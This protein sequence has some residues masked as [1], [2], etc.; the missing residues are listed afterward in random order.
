M[1]NQLS[2]VTV[3]VNQID[4][5]INGRPLSDHPGCGGL[6]VLNLF[7]SRNP[8]LYNQMLRL[9]V[10]SDLRQGRIPLYVCNTCGE[11]GCGCTTVSITRKGDRFIWSD[12]RFENNYEETFQQTLRQQQMRFDF[13]ASH[14]LE[15]IG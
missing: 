8:R 1:P 3:G 12:F 5:A 2:I 11:Y 9:E 14:Y 6:F 10:E 13:A 4:L 15:T 7:P